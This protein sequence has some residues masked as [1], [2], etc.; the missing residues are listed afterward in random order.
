MIDNRQG[1]QILSMRAMLQVATTLPTLRSSKLPLLKNPFFSSHHFLY[2]HKIIKYQA[3]DQNPNYEPSSIYDSMY[4]ENQ[5]SDA[6]D[7]MII[8]TYGRGRKVRR[9]RT[10]LGLRPGPSKSFR[11]VLYL[12]GKN[13]F[14]QRILTV[15]CCCLSCS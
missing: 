8:R 5:A 1:T 13:L 12:R 14:S 4:E 15:R 9:G 3:T 6:H 11:Q 10:R 2:R 7:I